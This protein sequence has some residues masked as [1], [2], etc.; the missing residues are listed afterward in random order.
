MYLFLCVFLCISQESVKKLL[1]HAF[2]SVI[3]NNYLQQQVFFSLICSF[4]GW[5]VL[6][7]M[8]ETPVWILS[9]GRMGND[10]FVHVLG[11]MCAGMLLFRY[12]SL[13]LRNKKST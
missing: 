7:F 12:F 6:W 5:L 11:V 2:T 1:Y 10:F 4:I 13:V 8:Q 9:D 3:I